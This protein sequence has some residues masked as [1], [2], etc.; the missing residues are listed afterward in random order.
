MKINDQIFDTIQKLDEIENDLEKIYKNFENLNIYDWNE[1][2][3]SEI[4]KREKL[5][6]IFW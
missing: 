5:F 3:I 2:S 4:N 1:M 6:A